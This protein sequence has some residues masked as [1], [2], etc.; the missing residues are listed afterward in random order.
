[1]CADGFVRKARSADFLNRAWGAL[2]A[3]TDAARDPVSIFLPLPPTWNLSA[4]DPALVHGR[5]LRHYITGSA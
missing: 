1:M 3:T 4:E 5:V 2:V